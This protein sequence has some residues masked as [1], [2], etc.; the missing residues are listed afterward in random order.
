M[1][2]VC[3]RHSRHILTPALL[4]GWRAGP[5]VD[6]KIIRDKNSGRSKGFAY[7]EYERRVGGCCLFHLLG[8][9]SPH[10]AC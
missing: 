8:P 2:S 9:A 3:Q 7:I 6:I 4:R 5:L 1:Q 10:S